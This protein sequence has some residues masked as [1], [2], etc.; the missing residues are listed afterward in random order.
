MT[1][2]V[3]RNSPFSYNTPQTSFAVAPPTGPTTYDVTSTGTTNGTQCFTAQSTMTVD[4]AT[5][6]ASGTTTLTHSSGTYTFG[7]NADGSQTITCPD[8]STF[9][10]TEEEAQT[11][12]APGDSSYCEAGETNVTGLPNIDDIIDDNACESDSDCLEGLKC[13]TVP[14]LGNMCMG[15]CI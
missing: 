14:T 3:A 2:I 8:N 9:T 5:E 7:Q 13:C 12:C 15:A 4:P 1:D 6:S 10:V 11:G